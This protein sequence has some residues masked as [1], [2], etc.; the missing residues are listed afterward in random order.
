M[1]IA[2]CKQLV[3]ALKLKAPKTETKMY[4]DAIIALVVGF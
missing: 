1:P 2:V 3:V 4:N